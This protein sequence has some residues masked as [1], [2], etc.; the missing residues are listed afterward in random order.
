M[1][2]CS[3]CRQEK[4][5]TDFNKNGKRLSS[6]CKSCTSQHYKDN[7]QK[8]RATMIAWEEKR[9]KQLRDIAVQRLSKGCVDC[10]QNNILT[11]EF[12]HREGKSNRDHSIA[13]LMNARCSPERL[14]EELEKTEVRC[15]NCHR[16]KTSYET[17]NSWRIQ[18]LT[19]EL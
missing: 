8:H 14:I 11:L 6:W 19:E 16:I 13:R 10:G 3:K 1:K 17:W 4:N 7:K 15:A 12:D 2:M 5:L 18:Y 9:N